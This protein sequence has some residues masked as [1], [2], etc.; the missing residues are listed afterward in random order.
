M[1]AGRLDHAGLP[2]AGSWWARPGNAAWWPEAPSGLA[3]PVTYAGLVRG[4]WRLDEPD[5]APAGL[6]WPG[7]VQAR[8]P[9]AWY[10]SLACGVGSAADGWDAALAPVTGWP[11]AG[12]QQARSV[13]SMSSGSSGLD[14]SAVALARGDSLYGIGLEALGGTRGAAGGVERMGRHLWGARLRLSR[15]AHRIRG[16]VSQ[17]G[18]AAKLSG[19]EE[20]AA[21]GQSGSAEWAWQRDGLRWSA[22]LAR[23]LGRHESFG[24]G[25]IDSERDA[26]ETRLSAAVALERGPREIES[27]VTWSDA[28]VRRSG[29]GSFSRQARSF[30]AVT[31]GSAPLAGGRLA[32]A[33]GAGRH[34]GVD[35]F[36]VAP[37]ADFARPWGRLAVS[38]HVERLLTPVWADLAPGFEPFLQHAWVGGARLSGDVAGSWRAR[39][40][41]R[42][43][44]VYSRAVVDRLPLEDLW[45]RSGLRAE[46]GTY[47]FVLGEGGI[48]HAGRRFDAG[49]EG[50]GLAHRRRAAASPAAA[51]SAL[52]GDPDRGVRAW[53]GA[54][55]RLF[56]GDLGLALRGEAAGVGA[57]QGGTTVARDLPAYVTFTLLGELSIGDVVAVW[58]LANLEDRLRDA[59]WTDRSTGRPAVEG[60]RDLQ[61]HLV[62]R[63]FN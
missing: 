54:R 18:T 22:A 10:D 49:L 34:G 24:G 55:A 27:R 47:D 25:L 2:D 37:S 39:A 62:W 19:G 57:R 43:G 15:G 58:R 45:L 41:V 59:A 1:G 50:F 14:E 60:R 42:G 31:R 29:Y 9:L 46:Y 17:R 20:Q 11:T 40:G 51:G 8:A 63:L 38:L 26:Q 5:R 36:D 7:L 32:L 23:G 56:R 12:G 3:F 52:N 33:L 30:W 44:R 53:L 21:R 35:R 4:G 13:F 16:N 61:M 28:E 48:E 6:P